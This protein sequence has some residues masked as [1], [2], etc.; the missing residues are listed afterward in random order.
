MQYGHYIQGNGVTMNGYLKIAWQAF[1]GGKTLQILKNYES[2]IITNLNEIHTY[3][4]ENFK[5]LSRYFQ[6]NG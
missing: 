2:S 4:W 5:N 6:R 1:D 3:P